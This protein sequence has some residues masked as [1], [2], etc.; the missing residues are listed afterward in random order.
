MGASVW[1]ILESTSCRTTNQ[2]SQTR[3]ETLNSVRYGHEVMKLLRGICKF[4][5][6]LLFFSFFYYF[7]VYYILLAFQILSN[8][9]IY[10]VRFY[11][12]MLLGFD[13]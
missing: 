7:Y 4:T 10:L 6:L 9:Y 11:F 5:R 1:R 2:T 13:R 12:I 3:Q 8:Y